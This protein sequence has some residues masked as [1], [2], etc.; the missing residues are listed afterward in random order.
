MG[1]GLS[2]KVSGKGS[3]KLG[4]LAHGVDSDPLSAPLRSKRRIPNV[5]P[6][7]S[8]HIFSPRLLS[9]MLN[10]LLTYLP[11]YLTPTSLGSVCAGMTRQ[12]PIL[13]CIVSSTASLCE[14]P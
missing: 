4:N 8:T 14:C 13:T 9:Y 12:V 10:R 5:Q 3:G 6:R 2:A 11:T 7:S 1:E